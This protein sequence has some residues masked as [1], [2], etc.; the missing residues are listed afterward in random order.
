MLRRCR[1][2]AVAPHPFKGP[3]LLVREH[4]LKVHVEGVHRAPGVKADIAGTHDVDR[5]VL[6]L[7]GALGRRGAHVGLDPRHRCAR[8]R[9]VEEMGAHEMDGVGGEY[10]LDRAFDAAV[11]PAGGAVDQQRVVRARHRQPAALQLEAARAHRSDAA[12]SDDAVG[13]LQLLELRQL[14]AGDGGAAESDWRRRLRIEP[15]EHAD[16][17]PGRQH[18]GGIG[19]R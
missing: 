19:C 16:R 2:Q 15:A 4:H 10:A 1:E 14:R 13:A 7:V 8:S 3:N 6:A 5:L 12:E 18:R 11:D 17:L 9:G